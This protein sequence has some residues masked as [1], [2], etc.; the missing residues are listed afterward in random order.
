M[1]AGNE[2]KVKLA[3]SRSGFPY[4]SLG[5]GCRWKRW[6][7]REVEASVGGFEGVVEAKRPA[8]ESLIVR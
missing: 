8:K 3:A 1:V 7:G 4:V 2:K 6:V 5:H